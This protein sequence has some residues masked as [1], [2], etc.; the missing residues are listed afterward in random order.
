MGVDN[1]IF[2]SGIFLYIQPIVITIF[3]TQSVI[4]FFINQCLAQGLHYYIFN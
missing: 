4:I 1:N 3:L 2:F